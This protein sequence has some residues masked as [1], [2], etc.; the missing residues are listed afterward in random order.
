MDWERSFDAYL[1]HL[2]EALGHNDRESGLK[3]IAKG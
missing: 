2:C 3:G 1:E